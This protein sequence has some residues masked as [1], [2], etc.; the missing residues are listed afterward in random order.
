MDSS[1]ILIQEGDI[2]WRV[3]ADLK[4]VGSGEAPAGDTHGCIVVLSWGWTAG[5]SDDQ[6]AELADDAPSQ[7]WELALTID[8][9]RELRD[10]LS[11]L[12][13]KF[14]EPPTS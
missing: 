13:T 1:A 7:R 5:M 3:S 6:R 12:L 11:A 8:S 4:P 10:N 2:Y 9:A 14:Q